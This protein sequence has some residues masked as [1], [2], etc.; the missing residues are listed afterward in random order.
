MSWQAQQVAH[1]IVNAVY[2]DGGYK[3]TDFMKVGIS[4]IAVLYAFSMMLL[5]RFRP[6]AQ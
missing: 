3:V 6:F 4:L 1:H 2:G 5:S